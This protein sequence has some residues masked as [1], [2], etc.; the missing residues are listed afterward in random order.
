MNFLDLFGKFFDCLVTFFGFLKKLDFSNFL[1]D[2]SMTFFR[3][4]DNFFWLCRRNLLKQILGFLDETFGISKKK[5]FFYL[6]VIFLEFL[7]IYC[8][9]EWVTR[10]ERPKGAK[11][12]V[13]EA[14]TRSRGPTGP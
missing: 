13:K 3:F 11:D 12:E 5:G 4:L 9:V 8:I 6:L 2:L 1:M 10:P 7:T 14:Q